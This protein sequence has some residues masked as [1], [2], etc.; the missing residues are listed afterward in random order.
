MFINSFM[1]SEMVTCFLCLP[2]WSVGI[3]KPAFIFLHK[4]RTA[5]EVVSCRLINAF[6]HTMR[7]IPHS[8]TVYS[9][10][11]DHLA[12]PLQDFLRL[13]IEIMANKKMRFSDGLSADMSDLSR[14]TNC[15]SN[16]AVHLLAQHQ[17]SPGAGSSDV[18]VSKS[19]STSSWSSESKYRSSSMTEFERE[20]KRK[21]KIKTIGT[22]LKTVMTGDRT[23]AVTVGDALWLRNGSDCPPKF[24][25]SMIWRDCWALRLG[26]HHGLSR[27]QC[28][29]SM[30]SKPVGE[31]V[32]TAAPDDPRN[33]GFD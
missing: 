16:R 26:Y 5:M 31:R 4:V 20:S 3:S 6:L 28:I 10:Y 17:S 12:L 23:I 13:S 15:S 2:R 22:K 14:D 1:S 7:E 27:Y 29:R 21:Q 18:F 32:I 19:S 33:N 30:A 9:K 24:C 8:L 11:L 25:G